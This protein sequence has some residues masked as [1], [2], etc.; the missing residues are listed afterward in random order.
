MIAGNP[1]FQIDGG[2]AADIVPDHVIQVVPDLADDAHC[3]VSFPHLT[4]F[5]FEAAVAGIEMDL[6]FARA[7]GADEKIDVFPTAFVRK[8]VDPAVVD[9][10]QAEVDTVRIRHD[11]RVFRSLP[12]AASHNRNNQPNMGTNA[13]LPK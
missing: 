8:K 4:K 13:V 6:Q 3:Q 2:A 1:A 11:D 5:V 7:D 9:G 10:R 12:F